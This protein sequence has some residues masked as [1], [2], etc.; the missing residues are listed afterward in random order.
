MRIATGGEAQAADIEQ[1]IQSIPNM[2]VN[3]PGYGG[4][5][6]SK[7]CVPPG[8]TRKLLCFSF[9]FRSPAFSR[10]EVANETPVIF[11]VKLFKIRFLKH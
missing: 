4:L 8:Q 6:V 2:I 1:I 11:L 5:D 10:P 3:V 9:S 7:V